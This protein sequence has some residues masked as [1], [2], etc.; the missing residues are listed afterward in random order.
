MHAGT[1]RKPWLCFHCSSQSSSR[2]PGGS[3]GGGELL[4]RL[5]VSSKSV[6]RMHRAGARSGASPSL[7]V[8]EQVCLCGRQ[9][10]RGSVD[11]GPMCEGTWLPS[12]RMSDLPLRPTP[13]TLTIPT[14]LASPPPLPRVASGGQSRPHSPISYVSGVCPSGT[15]CGTQRAA[16][17]WLRSGGPA[18]LFRGQCAD[19]ATFCPRSCLLTWTGTQ[20]PPQARPRHKDTSSC[21][22]SA[23]GCR[24]CRPDGMKPPAFGDSRSWSHASGKVASP[25]SSHTWGLSPSGSRQLLL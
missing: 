7:G 25:V 10:Q 12:T 21:G 3:A 22:L 18:V 15:E 24:L 11:S 14:D 5:Q 13:E 2:G 23:D 19:G 1:L 6:F 8:C 4:S 20:C 9:G 16:S 17:C